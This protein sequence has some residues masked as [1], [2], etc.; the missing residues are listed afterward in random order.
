MTKRISFKC[1][2]TKI[3]LLLS[4]RRLIKLNTETFDAY[5]MYKGF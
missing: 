3:G 4:F 5:Y 2:N 1:R